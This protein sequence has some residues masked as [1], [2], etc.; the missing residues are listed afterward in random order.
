MM[1]AGDGLVVVVV[2]TALICLRLTWDLFLF[3]LGAFTV[4]VPNH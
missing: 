4:I 3:E 2:L 1:E